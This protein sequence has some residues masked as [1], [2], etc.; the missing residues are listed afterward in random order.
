MKKLFFTIP[1]K[2]TE[3][4]L[5]SVKLNDLYELYS[6]AGYI[7]LIPGE[8][9]GSAV[10]MLIE[11]DVVYM[12]EGW[13]KYPDCQDFLSIAKNREKKLIGAITCGGNEHNPK[14]IKKTVLS[15]LDITEDQFSSKLRFKEITEARQIFCSICRN[16]TSL[17]LS[18]IGSY[19]RSGYSHSDVIH[20]CEKARNLYEVEYKYR[21]KYWEIEKLL[22]V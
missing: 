9:F 15:Y 20:A 16:K 6:Q 1:T 2:T 8:S 17:S 3:D 22:D 7:I 4:F 5:S 21:L 18:K 11:C 10:E 12:F 19:V 13:E 14:I